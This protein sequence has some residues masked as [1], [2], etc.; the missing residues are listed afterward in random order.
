[1]TPRLNI[2]TS[3]SRS[4]TLRR[5]HCSLRWNR[6]GNMS[7]MAAP[8]T[9][10]VKPISRENLGTNR[11]SRYD[12]ISEAPRTNRAGR[13]IPPWP[14]AASVERFKQP[15]REGKQSFRQLASHCCLW[16]AQVWLMFSSFTQVKSVCYFKPV[17][18]FSFFKM[19]NTMTFSTR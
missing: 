16:V 13:D 18:S 8:V 1:M 14:P 3:I 10:P 19:C 6:H 2:H 17:K 11:A 9:L 4:L 15:S 5:S 7:V 12:V